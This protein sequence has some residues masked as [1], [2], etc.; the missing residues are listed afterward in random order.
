M[1]TEY[2]LAEQQLQRLPA[3]A[4]A[5]ALALAVVGVVHHVAL[6]DGTAPAAADRIRRTVHALTDI[7]S[8]AAS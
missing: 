4:D 3:D 2:V 7:R 6:T 5:A 8:G 1:T